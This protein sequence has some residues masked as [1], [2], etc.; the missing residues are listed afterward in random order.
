M[1]LAVYPNLNKEQISKMYA[2]EL[3]LESVSHFT[4]KFAKA[5]EERDFWGIGWINNGLNDKAKKI[6]SEITGYKLPKTQKGSLLVLLEW[7]KIDY[8][9]YDIKIKE[10]SF[11]AE[12]KNVIEKYN[13]PENDIN[14]MF[15]QLKDKNLWHE[16]E[17]IR[18]GIRLKNLDGFCD[19]KSKGIVK[20]RPVIKS[21][22]AY[23]KAVEM[24]DLD[25][26]VNDWKEQQK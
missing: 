8:L 12:L 14:S 3:G 9:D 20:L 10:Q 17:E 25:N 13:V 26:L 15:D 1:V 11:N 22:V 4:D 7:A 18:G 21:W 5:I 23:M 19:L 24:K 6:F 16:Y 2:K